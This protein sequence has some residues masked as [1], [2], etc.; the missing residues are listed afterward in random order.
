MFA[1]LLQKPKAAPARQPSV[2]AKDRSLTTPTP[3]PS[4]APFVASHNLRNIP[5]HPPQ[6]S[7]KSP[8]QPDLTPDPAPKLTAVIE[9]GETWEKEADQGARSLFTN[10]QQP[11]T[12]TPLPKSNSD[13]TSTSKQ[14]SLHP[15]TLT[16]GGDPLSPALSSRFGQHFHSDFNHVRV[17]TGNTAA[18]ANAALDSE[19]FTYGSHIWLAD[20]SPTH[21]PLLAHELV[22]VMQQSPAGAGDSSHW[23]I[24]TKRKG[25]GKLHIVEIIAFENSKD[26]AQAKLDDGSVED[27]QLGENTFPIG[28][29]TLTQFG[30]SEG[31]KIPYIRKNVADTKGGF[32]W[33]FNSVFDG[34][35]GP[36]PSVIVHILPGSLKN[37]YSKIDALDAIDAGDKKQ[38]PLSPSHQPFS[39]FFLSYRGGSV[40]TYQNI[41]QIA[42]ADQILHD[43]GVTEG[44]LLIEQQKR[45]NN[46]DLG[47]P[48][49]E[50]LDAKQWAL[51]FVSERESRLEKELGNTIKNRT[52]LNTDIGTI[53]TASKNLGDDQQDTIDRLHVY[54][55]G[56]SKIAVLDG[57]ADQELR[58][59]NVDPD[60]FFANF[61]AEMRS[62]MRNL[63]P[64]TQ[65]ELIRLEKDYLNDTNDDK[66]KSVINNITAAQKTTDT[67]EAQLEQASQ[68]QTA[69]L[70]AGSYAQDTPE[71]LEQN[72]AEPQKQVAAAKANLQ[73]ITSNASLSLAS[74]GGIKLDASSNKALQRTKTNLRDFIYHSRN[75]LKT[76]EETL[77][78]P[79]KTKSLYGAD[80]IVALTKGLIGI[81]PGSLTDAIINLHAADVHAREPLWKEVLN[82]IVFVSSFID[83]PISL[84]FRA[85]VSGFNFAE[86]LNTYA[87][88]DAVH[89]S[90][91]SSQAPGK[92]GLILSAGGAVLDV[93]SLGSEL[94]KS[95][96]GI[97]RLGPILE[98]DS[99]A[100]KAALD[101]DAK[102]ALDTA[103]PKPSVHEAD[104]AKP[105]ADNPG[106]DMRGK[107]NDDGTVTVGG[108][109]EPEPNVPDPA[110]QYGPTI[111]A[112]ERSEA[113]AA[114]ARAAERAQIQAAERAQA[115]AAARSA[116]EAE[117]QGLR[118][119]AKALQTNK[120]QFGK[121]LRGLRRN[122]TSRQ[123]ALKRLAAAKQD[124][125]TLAE[126]QEVTE[127]LKGYEA[128]A[129][130][131]ETDLANAD[132][133]LQKA[134]DEAR[135]AV[136][137][138]RNDPGLGVLNI[139]DAPSII[140]VAGQKVKSWSK[141]FFLGTERS[142][143]RPT[144]EKIL[145]EDVN[146]P[147]SKALLDPATGKLYP[148][149]IPKGGKLAD[150]LHRPEVF[151]SAHALTRGAGEEVFVIGSLYKNQRQGNLIEKGFDVAATDR[152]YIIQ[153]IAIDEA[154][155]NA[156]VKEGR[157]LTQADLDSAELFD[158]FK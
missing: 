80:R 131:V 50:A 15:D 57:V 30:S 51:N 24:Q 157:G 75:S 53:E 25:D 27:I 17:H 22:H 73:K 54:A 58:K 101:E 108:H 145:Q 35:S 153:G 148:G 26:N 143:F 21:L 112:A 126:T 91:F 13:S 34:P 83:G 100:A 121:R 23:R 96:A 59:L 46:E 20:Q 137:D 52:A 69:Q 154:T 68:D 38:K 92:L 11:G 90:A 32:T 65:I 2:A 158:L 118:A 12:P 60:V 127:V 5:V 85:A 39:R 135:I 110:P 139:E 120:T 149:L 86:A 89:N 79:S 134:R 4:R 61:E 107:Q 33:F 142:E 125:K 48:P 117:L 84:A 10:S 111:S 8:T 9:P 76:A 87:E 103:N 144:V 128:E 113:Q 78:D 141:R 136:L 40:A 67:A 62:T 106:P 81:Q 1:P 156:L 116:K 70:S 6:S 122:I 151:Q 29:Y 129:K 109:P 36:T 28:D 19:A 82:I 55:E 147:L 124:A 133:N 130:Q 45:E 16:R 41:A 14:T 114:A 37:L 123:R 119:E 105:P 63:L 94:Q 152:A 88:Q 7:H 44:E 64:P 150:Y 102:A 74:R 138:L 155:A 3:A 56:R 115:R 104:A 97:G 42:E 98:G 49:T 31:G 18:H 140:S 71:Q 99:A 47:I 77:S 93:S 95:T 66:L 132:A 72:I 146:G 43:A